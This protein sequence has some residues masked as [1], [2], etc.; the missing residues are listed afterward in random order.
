MN[1]AKFSFLFL[2]GIIK[3]LTTCLAE[4]E[5]R[6][7]VEDE[8]GEIIEGAFVDCY[9]DDHAPNTDD[10]MVSGDTGSDGCVTLTYDEKE[11]KVL[12][13]CQDNWDACLKGLQPDIFCRIKAFCFKTE[14]TYTIKNHDQVTVA[15]FG[16]VVLEENEGYCGPP[17]EHNGCGPF[18]LPDWLREFLNEFT[19]FE[20]AC[21]NQ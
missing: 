5:I 9:D 3:F 7:C 11:N 18:F 13:A 20:M 16:T 19:G 6:V 12:L 14:N 21:N 1:H 10:P 15:D 4:G 17:D 8:E 2:L